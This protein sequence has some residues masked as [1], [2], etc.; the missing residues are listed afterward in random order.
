MGTSSRE[1]ISAARTVVPVRRLEAERSDPVPPTSG[2]TVTSAPMRTRTSTNPI[3]SAPRWMPSTARWLPGTTTPA[4]T[5]KAACDGSPGTSTVTGRSGDGRMRMVRPDPTGST[6]MSAPACASSS[7]VWARVRTGSWTTVSPS[8][9][10]A[11]SSTADFT[12]ALAIG[13]V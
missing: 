8:A 13:G 3:R 1:G 12:W 10:V 5:Q 2:T 6:S 4:T 11:A 7:S 9:P